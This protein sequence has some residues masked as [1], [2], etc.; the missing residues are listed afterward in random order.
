MILLSHSGE[1]LLSKK[2]RV[3]DINLQKSLK[4]SFELCSQSSLCSSSSGFCGSLGGLVLPLILL[5]GTNLLLSVNV[6]VDA[7]DGEL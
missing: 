1:L 6:V 5:L 3:E 4:L 7:V 2:K